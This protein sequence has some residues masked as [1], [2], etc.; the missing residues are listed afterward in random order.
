MTPQTSPADPPGET[1]RT[2]LKEL[3]KRR[4]WGT[5]AFA[6]ACA[7]AGMPGLTQSSIENIES[8]RRRN[9]TIEELAVLAYA[10]G[11][12]P[13]VLL[14]PVGDVDQVEVLPGRAVDTWSAAKWFT[15]EDPLPTWDERENR[16][17]VEREDVAQWEQGA[18][19]VT[20]YR[21]HDQLRR[22][23]A[24]LLQ[25]ARRVGRPTEPPISDDALRSRVDAAW[26]RVQSID[27]EIRGIRRT[28]RTLGLIPPVLREGLRY[29]DDPN[30]TTDVDLVMLAEM[31]TIEHHVEDD[32]DG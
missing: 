26:E 11:V 7:A 25:V 16:W 13:V 17:V 3:R 14:F 5:A 1:A 4:G 10:L 15:G 6:E 31:A 19:A 24:G 8:G 18:A 12:P 2:R 9:I 27:N 29:L 30:T 32:A 23:R 28:L 22:Q 20:L 21:M